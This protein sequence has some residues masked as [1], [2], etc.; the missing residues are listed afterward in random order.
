MLDV[1]CGCSNITKVGDEARKMLTCVKDENQRFLK[2]KCLDGTCT[3]CP[4]FAAVRKCGL[5]DERGTGVQF[6][7][8]KWANY[9]GQHLLAD[10]TTKDVH[11]EG[12]SRAA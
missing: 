7:R 2:P 3:S 10:G 12:S 5:E 9:K 11:D 6:L 1:N 8:D 4:G